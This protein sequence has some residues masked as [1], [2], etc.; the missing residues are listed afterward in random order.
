MGKFISEWKKSHGAGDLRSSHVGQQVVLMGWVDAVRPHGKAVFVDVR[1]RAGIA[2]V[3]F[4]EATSSSQ[5]V[6]VA[7]ALRQE[8][9]VAVRGVVRPRAGKSN[10][11]LLSGEVEVIVSEAE[12]LN[13]SAP[14]PFAIADEVDA[15]ETTRLKYRFL[16]LRRPPLR[17]AMM[18]RARAA[19]IV[20]DHFDAEGFIEFETPILTKSTPE[21]A[22]DYLVPSRVQQGSFYALPQSPQLFKQLLQVA[23]FERYYQICRCFRD[24]D[25]RADRQPEFTQIDVE[26][27]FVEAED[28]MEVC[29]RLVAR[30]FMELRGVEVPAQIPCITY[31]EAMERYGVD[32][33]DVRFG[34]ELK[35]VTEWVVDSPF[36]A[37][38]SAAKTGRVLGLKVDG[39]ALMSRKE[40]DE[41]TE[42]VKNYG[43]KGV[44]NLKRVA[45]EYSG[46]IAKFVDDG[47]RKALEEKLEMKDG[48]LA[49]LVADPDKGVARTACGRLRGHLGHKLG[50]IRPNS[51]GYTWVTAFPMFERDA[52]SGRL[53]AMHHPFT[54]PRPEHL[55][56]LE[57]DPLAVRANAYDIVV[58]GQELGGGSIRIH[59]SEVQSKVFSA[60]GIGEHEA[61]I[62]FGFLLDALSFGAPPH[63]GLAFGFDRLVAV[64]AGTDSIRDVIAFPKTTRA[65]CLMTDAPSA[66]DE[67]QL[68]ELGIGLLGPRG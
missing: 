64:L 61:R 35:D 27:S 45:G 60:L 38:Q 25:L 46:G 57:S 18:M 3:V 14:M 58:N 33:P 5:A 55:H 24:E 11:N 6:E 63:G 42:F 59:S 19:K 23:G 17:K 47:L 34:M 2:Q 66:V 44:A 56:L 8:Y 39:G 43:G 7:A 31:D 13:R 67:A 9:V 10:P 68:R 1:D 37:F 28:V 65:A 49:L 22:R 16:D 36:G 30:L 51:F 48:D 4:D 54:S 32:N 21:G 52:Q 29:G 40:L 50:L 20:R 41:L 53:V 15:S 62:K 12:L 26:M